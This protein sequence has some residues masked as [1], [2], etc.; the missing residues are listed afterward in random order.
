MSMSC[1]VSLQTDIVQRCDVVTKTPS[2]HQVMNVILTSYSI[3]SLDAKPICYSQHA[4]T[5]CIDMQRHRYK[6][7]LHL[8]EHPR[9]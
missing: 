7:S 9:S 4:L 8:C 2:N 5:Q 1:R 3:Y 6:W